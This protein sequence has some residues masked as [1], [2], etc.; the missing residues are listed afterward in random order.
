MFIPLHDGVK[1]IF[2]KR[3][4]V[5]L[6]LIACNIAVYAFTF[7]FVPA[8][9]ESLNLSF[10]LIPSVLTGRAAIAPE[11][12][13]V[14]A[15]LT[16]VT[17]MFLHAGFWHLVANMLFLWVFGD[18]VEDAM[19]SV[20]FLGFYLA[21]GALAGLL[22][23]II[24]PDSRSPLIG[25]SGAVSG[26]A[27]AYLLLYPRARIIGLLLNW[28]PLAAPAILAIGLWIMF[29]LVSA[30]LSADPAVAWWAHVGGIVA[31]LILAPLFKRSDVPLFGG[32]TA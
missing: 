19:G 7:V 14:P 30:S 21:C 17:S 4:F 23:V 13:L 24:A 8:P 27:S 5:T 32:R 31:G 26:V 25:A 3:P 2:L 6:G 9:D 16:P 1:L 15:I 28:I 12:Q 22:F 18:N 29:Q 10:G 20:R 11:L